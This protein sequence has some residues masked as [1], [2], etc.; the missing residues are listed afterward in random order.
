MDLSVNNLFQLGRR[1]WWLL[2]LAPLVAGG[3]AFIQVS[4]QQE[5]YSSSATVEINPPS[6]GADTFSFYDPSIVATYRELITTT[7]VLGP[8]VDRLDL[9]ITETELRGKISTE[10]VADTRLMRIAVSDPD[11]ESAAFL[12]NQVAEEFQ[13][14]AELRTRQL[15]GPYRAALE[16]QIEETN[17][18]IGLTQQ[19]I[20]DL[21]ARDDVTAPETA[22][23]IET[24]RQ[25]L[26]DLQGT[27]RELI[28]SVNR[29]DLETAGAQ[30]GVVVVQDAEPPSVP[31]APDVQLYTLLAAFAGLCLAVGAIAIYEYF[32]NTTKV[33]TPFPELVGAP[34]LATI[35][36]IPGLGD[37]QHHQLFLID[38][39]ASSPSEAVRLLRTNVEF[40]AAGNEIATLAVTSSGPSEGKS[41]VVANLG[42]ALAQAGFSVAVVDA[43]LRRP[44][45]H[46]IFAVRNERG[47]SNLL[48]KPDMKWQEVARAIPGLSLFLI[49]SGPIPPNP[50]DLLRSE[51]LQSLLSQIS[52]QVDIVLV[53][54]PP[55]LAASDALL[56][57]D[58]TDAVLMVCRAN[59]TR[60]DKLQRAVE[61]LPD[62]AR[63]IGVLLNQH[64]RQGDED[65][66]YYY[67]DDSAGGST[68]SGGHQTLNERIRGWPS[69]PA[70]RAKTAP[71]SEA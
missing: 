47:L 71:E 69:K 29:M 12:A 14:F 64:K 9:P 62:S 20:D 44:T 7:A 2:L 53:D 18:N 27:Y 60:I 22:A 15:I 5:L 57:S 4:R 19:L 16:Q 31:Y 63:I 34:L 8:L 37:A 48:A 51:Q 39:P 1:W 17:A 54:T 70:S 36:I 59:H 32:D 61:A 11:P 65:Y 23:Q 68:G 3:V 66:D 55:A 45:L 58:S 40:A 42:A 50:A 33:E 56:I 6:V 38:Q 10:P 35:P 28:V 41:T 46:K 13:A 43:D 26:R 21:V 25:N 52:S 67:V 30:T 24:L 49:T